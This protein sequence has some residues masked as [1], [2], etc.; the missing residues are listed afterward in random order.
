MDVMVGSLT[1]TTQKQYDSA[2]RSWWK[3]CSDTN[4]SVFS[5][6]PIQVIRFFQYLFR[7]KSFRYG[8]FNN[9]RS[10]LTLIM[11]DNL[12]KHPIIK[13]YIRGISKVRPQNPRYNITWDPQILLD[14]LH[15]L[16]PNEI[17]SLELLSK[18]LISLMALITAQRFQ[19]FNLIK[20]E[21]IIFTNEGEVLIFISDAIKTSGPNK[22]QPCLQFQSFIENPELCLVSTLLQY[23][24]K[25]ANLRDTNNEYLFISY[26]NPFNRVSSQTLSRWVKDSMTKAGINTDIFSGYSIKHAATSTAFKR[27]LPINLIRKTAGWTEN[28]GTFARFYNR[29]IIRTTDSLA[30]VLINK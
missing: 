17:L 28:S 14:Y 30:K 18:K 3:Y 4:I 23:I 19:T 22:M 7:Q 29:P 21:N 24:N 26:S 9:I 2:Y 13:R 5:A 8:S 11:P 16:Y 15:S 20:V 12:G 1:T 25:T 10:A 6:T 27:G